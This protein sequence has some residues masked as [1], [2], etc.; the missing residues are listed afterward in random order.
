[1]NSE[2]KTKLQE[3]EERKKHGFLIGHPGF[4]TTFS[5]PGDDPGDSGDDDST[6][7]DDDDL[8]DDDQSTGDDD[9][10]GDDNTEYSAG[11]VDAILKSANID[12]NQLLKDNPELKKQYQARFNKNMSK[13]LD[14]F[15]DVDVDKYNELLQRE[16]EGKLEGDAETWK[17]KHDAL[18]DQVN[19]MSQRQAI[20]QTAL[21]LK[22]DSEQ[23]AFISE[24]I[25]LSALDKDDEGEWMGI[26]DEIERIK[27]KFPR[28]FESKADD[29]DDPGDQGTG[30]QQRYNPGK[31]KQGGSGKELTPAERGRLRAQQRHNIKK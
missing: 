1:M 28:M 19:Q 20:Q 7:G 3:Y 15:K 25:N 29:Q 14:K 27:T 9:N 4:L 2:Q 22:M 17:N 13:R 6:G 23:T 10:T 26:D 21:N 16:S 5:D 30:K 31:Q 18:L 11:A 8:G 24:M 12:F